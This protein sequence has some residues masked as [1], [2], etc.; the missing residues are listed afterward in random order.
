MEL[1]D[2]NLKRFLANHPE[3]IPGMSPVKNDRIVAM[4]TMV[5]RALEICNAL[6]YIHDHGVVHRDLKTENILVS[7]TAVAFLILDQ[8][9]T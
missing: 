7:L 4:R 8:Y 5:Q 1:C 3:M 2:E 9:Y 6:R